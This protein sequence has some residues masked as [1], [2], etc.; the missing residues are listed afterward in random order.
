MALTADGELM[1]NMWATR[2]WYIFSIDC[3]R[4]Q[5][6]EQHWRSQQQAQ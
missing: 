1:T 2:P 5:G 3:T 6:N 4:T